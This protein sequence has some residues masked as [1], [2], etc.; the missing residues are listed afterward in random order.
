MPGAAPRRLLRVN[1]GTDAN[2]LTDLLTFMPNAI[3]KTSKQI[4]GCENLQNSMCQGGMSEQWSW[5][6]DT[7]RQW[8]TGILRGAPEVVHLQRWNVG[9]ELPS[10]VKWHFLR[11]NEDQLRSQSMLSKFQMGECNDFWKEIKALNPQKE[12]VP[13]TVG[14]TSGESNISNLL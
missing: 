4:L 3:P 5:M 10:G 13:L 9:H 11:K 1:R 14:S 7:R 6:L 2:S 12:S 8:A